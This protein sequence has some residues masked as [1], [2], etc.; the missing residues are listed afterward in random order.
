V[1]IVEPEI[2]IEG[3]HDIVMAAAASQRVISRC[4]ARLWQQVLLPGCVFRNRSGA[5]DLAVILGSWVRL[6]LLLMPW[7][8]PMHKSGVICRHAEGTV[9]CSQLSELKLPDTAPTH[10]PAHRRRGCRWRRCC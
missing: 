8:C 6:W 9:E 4:V 5:S 1:P 7:W 3:G 2:L 10:S